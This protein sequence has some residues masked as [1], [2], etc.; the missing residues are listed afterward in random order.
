[1]NVWKYRDGL[2]VTECTSFPYAFRTMFNAVR[3]GTEKGRNYED[4]MKSMRIISPA[5]DV[6]GDFRTYNFDEASIMAKN[7]GLLNSDG[8]INSREFKR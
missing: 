2:A 7:N 8:T 3:R 5:K 1:M 4:M 6:H